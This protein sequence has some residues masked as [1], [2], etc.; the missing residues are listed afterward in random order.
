M[1][2]K[3]LWG[4]LRGILQV[5]HIKEGEVVQIRVILVDNR[6]RLETCSHKLHTDPFLLI[7][8]AS[9]LFTPC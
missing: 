2:G 4:R 5:H 6:V 7:G 3:G 9:P 1:F 8:I